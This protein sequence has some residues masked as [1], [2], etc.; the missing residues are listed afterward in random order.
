[1]LT[2]FSILL[3]SIA[4]II[5]AFSYNVLFLFAA[6]VPFGLGAGMVDADHMGYVSNNW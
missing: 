2:F 3:T 4:L 1:M 6:A 5:F